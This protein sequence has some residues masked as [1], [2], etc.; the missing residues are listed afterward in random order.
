VHRRS[1]LKGTGIVTVAV[2]GGGVWRA[3]EQGVF[4]VGEGPAYE[5]W[6]DWRNAGN[7]EPLAL[8][9][10]A[11]LAASPH[12]TQP[13]LFKIS[14]SA[15]ELHIDTQRNV[16]ALDP[17]LREEH[18]GMGCALENLLLAAPANGYAATAE[19][20]PGKLGPIAGEPKTQ[21][22]ARVNLAAG[23]REESELYNAIPLRH[24]NRGP[25]DP[26]RAISPDFLDALRHVPDDCPDVKLFLFTAEADRKK[27]AEI[28]SGANAEIYS[29][30]DVQR[31][32]ERWMRTQ[33]SSVQKYRDG[34]TIDAFGLPPLATAI[35]KMMSARMLRWAASR[36]TDNGYANLMLSAPLIG[37]IAVRDRY[38]QEQ[39]LQAGRIWQRAHLFATARGLAARPCNEIVEMVDHERALGRPASR[40]ALLNEIT[41]DPAWQPTFVFYMGYAKLTAHA[42]PRR[43]VQAVLV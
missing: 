36:S 32:S 7:D 6:N 3:E 26:R 37:F 42:S 8:V 15:I 2:V 11:I 38:A 19:L 22:L 33:W 10:A 30:P 18:I 20:L 28:S 35:A 27:I 12:N 24:T 4:S 43:P 14:D 29:D 13:W 41:A 34:L 39:C 31:G 21:L 9:R 40:V 25:Y 23:K 17:F 1:F 5:P 16:G